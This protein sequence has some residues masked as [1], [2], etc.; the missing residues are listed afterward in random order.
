[1]QCT[2]VTFEGEVLAT[3]N[4]F[5]LWCHIQNA[6]THDLLV[7]VMLDPVYML[8]EVIQQVKVEPLFKM[9]NIVV[10]ILR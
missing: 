1:M 5:Y 7:G 4:S 9:L 2:A 6:S 3:S 10:E 8:E